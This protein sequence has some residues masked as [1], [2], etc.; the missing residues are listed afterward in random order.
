MHHTYVYAVFTQVLSDEIMRKDATTLPALLGGLPW[1]LLR[2]QTAVRRHEQAEDRNAVHIAGK[3]KQR[4]PR[5]TSA[6]DFNFFSSL[7]RPILVG[8][9]DILC[10]EASPWLSLPCMGSPSRR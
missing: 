9:T 2:F 6:A 5:A 4:S 1:L 7:L 8:L 10:L 3:G